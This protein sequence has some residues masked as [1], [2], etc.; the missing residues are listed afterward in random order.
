MPHKFS[1]NTFKV[2]QRYLSQAKT[3][4][5]S[6]SSTDLFF[7]HT[8]FDTERLIE[9][10]KGGGFTTSQS[11]VV[12]DALLQL[13]NKTMEER[14]KTAANKAELATLRS[15]L[16][17]LEK[18]DIYILKSDVQTLEKKMEMQW[19]EITTSMEHIENR[20]IKMVIASAGTAAAIILFD[21][22]RE[23]RKRVAEQRR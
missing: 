16:Q 13:C 9:R 6:L 15:E 17:I 19:A 2:F 21:L 5:T 1:S 8:L 3:S 10:L 18:T 11:E 4:E 7:N 23:K 12:C 22:N 20:V 14:D